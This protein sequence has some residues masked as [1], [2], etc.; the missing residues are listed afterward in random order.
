[1]S[2]A[3]DMVEARKSSAAAKAKSY[4]KPPV[5]A[6]PGVA[7]ALVRIRGTVNVNGKVKDTMRMLRVQFPNH[8][9]IIPS[10]ES[11]LGMIQ[12]VTDYV[13]WGEVEPAVVAELLKARGKTVGDEPLTDEIVKKSSDGKYATMDA[14][15]AALAK[16]EAKMTDLG[17]G[18]KPLF[19]LQPPKG[20]HGTIKR[21]VAAGGP[22]GYHGKGVNDLIRRMI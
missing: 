16:G 3:N 7:Y 10:T 18:V 15:A 22:L 19:R 12:K 9:A 8:V 6:V 14:F 5:K 1:M 17:D 11:N 4:P 21:H 2:S 13:A 20:G